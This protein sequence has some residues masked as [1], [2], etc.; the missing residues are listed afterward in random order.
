VFPF[1]D[2]DHFF[3]V[4]HFD[5]YRWKKG[6]VDECFSFKTKMIN[7]H[8]KVTKYWI[9]GAGAMIPCANTI[10]TAFN[11]V[12]P[13]NYTL[14]YKDDDRE[15]CRL[16][17]LCWKPRENKDGKVMGVSYDKGKKKWRVTR[18]GCKRSCHATREEAIQAM[19]NQGVVVEDE[20]DEEVDE[21][22]EPEELSDDEMT[23]EEIALNKRLD[24]QFEANEKRNQILSASKVE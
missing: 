14:H 24:E 23:P 19:L 4:D 18:A 1:K 21:V 16:T 5:L 2:S 13:G 22:I 9:L 7:K 10:C 3:V 6:E 17:N 11:G 8:D 20:A 12:R 15:N